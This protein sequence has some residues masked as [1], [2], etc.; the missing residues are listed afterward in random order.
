MVPSISVIDDRTLKKKKKRTVWEGQLELQL[1]RQEHSYKKKTAYALKELKEY[2]F[3]IYA[4]YIR[5]KNLQ[6]LLKL[7]D[8][9][10][11]HFKKKPRLVEVRSGGRASTES[12][13]RPERWKEAE[14]ERSRPCYSVEN[15]NSHGSS[16]HLLSTPFTV[17][18]LS[19]VGS[20]W[21]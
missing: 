19:D 18:A 1:V 6:T 9:T 5:K 13:S 20:V 12:K 21:Y 3:P 16:I 7:K 14:E 8:R 15:D 17:S 2:R 10:L 4:Y 11:C